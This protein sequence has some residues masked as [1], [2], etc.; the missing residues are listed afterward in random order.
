VRVAAAIAL[1]A[2]SCLALAQVSQD[3][4]LALA[5]ELNLTN[6]SVVVVGSNI[7]GPEAAML[8]LARS[9]IP[10]A[11]AP[12]YYD[13]SD[14]TLTLLEN[15]T[16][17]IVLVGGPSQNE[18]SR[19]YWNRGWIAS[20]TKK[21]IGDFMLKA[22]RTRDGAPVLLITDSRGFANVKKEGAG[23][24]PLRFVMDEKYV[25][26]AA[27][28]VTILLMALF[29]LARTALERF[30]LGLG[31]RERKVREQALRLFGI[32][33]REVASLILASLVLAAAIT[34]VFTG[35][36]PAFIPL[37]LVNIIVALV[38]VVGH[39][40][41]HLVFGRMFG[42]RMEY[43]FWPI[44]SLFTLF[45]AYLGNPFG[46]AGFLVEE[47]AQGMRMKVAVMKLAAPLASIAF[48]FLF[49]I[50]N[51]FAPWEIF[52]MTFTI[53]ST[54]AIV[55]LLPFEPFD[56]AAVRR[57]SIFAWFFPFCAVALLY[58]VVNFIL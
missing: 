52:Q 2:F 43:V 26:A 20:E 53:A 31:R 32:K 6:E 28:G 22:G 44:G 36:T 29:A 40:L 41:V 9:R 27:T 51:L 35:P 10:A 21:S 23:V 58:I 24:S 33:L 37:L 57:W 34:W 16:R 45:S 19:E 42:L 5:L 8:E 17:N 49:A 54:L 56:G 12:T 25:P 1:L 55:E 38:T 39:E 30:F 3:E 15:E 47:E 11:F 48:A 13:D 18:I 46:L 50:I 4:A 7:D 14:A